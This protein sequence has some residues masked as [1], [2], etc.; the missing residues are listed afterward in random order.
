MRYGDSLSSL[1]LVSSHS[2]EGGGFPIQS[3]TWQ[4]EVMSGSTGSSRAPQYSRIQ[5][6]RSLS[7]C[8]LNY[9]GVQVV[10]DSGYSLN[11]SLHPES[12]LEKTIR[13]TD[14]VIM[15]NDD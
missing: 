9:G 10:R 4:V 12:Q 15:S 8:P 3:G 13:P 1:S 5:S 2:G 7:M 6:M 11:C 14:E